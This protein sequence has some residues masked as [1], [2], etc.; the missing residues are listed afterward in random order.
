M[1]LRSTTAQQP[2]SYN[3]NLIPLQTALDSSPLP[4]SPNSRFSFVWSRPFA[5]DQQLQLS[6]TNASSQIT[7]QA[8][9]TNCAASDNDYLLTLAFFDQ[10][11][12]FQFRMLLQLSHIHRYHQQEQ[13][14]GRQLCINEA[15]SEWI[16]RFA[17][18]FPSLNA[19]I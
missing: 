17:E 4:D 19:M 10:A 3:L 9:V 11:Q 2:F 16:S 1:S 13:D 5:L 6:F 14:Q 15:A 18:S 12:A 7:A 8:Q